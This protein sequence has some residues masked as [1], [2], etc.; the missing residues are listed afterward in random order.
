[1]EKKKFF[2]FM[3]YE[4]PLENPS[5]SWQ[6]KMYNLS[7]YKVTFAADGVYLRSIYHLYKIIR[8]FV[9]T[10]DKYDSESTLSKLMMVAFI[11]SNERRE[12]AWPSGLGFGLEIRRSRVQVSL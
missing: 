11:E 12:A 8:L 2:K 4:D 10:H 1:M 7:K 6:N 9:T 3:L 5:G